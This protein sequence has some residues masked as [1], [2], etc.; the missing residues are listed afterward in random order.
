MS[1]RTL[2]RWETEG[3][4]TRQ[5]HGKRAERLAR[6]AEMYGVPVDVLSGAAA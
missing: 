1:A 3:L 6:L 2:E 4:P 5:N